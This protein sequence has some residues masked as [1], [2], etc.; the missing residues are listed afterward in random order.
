[1]SPRQASKLRAIHKPGIINKWVPRP[2]KLLNIVVAAPFVSAG[3]IIEVPLPKQVSHL[4]GDRQTV[5][6][7]HIEDGPGD[8][9]PGKER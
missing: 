6:H 7:V 2:L 5:F 1:M 4:A 9:S 3:R 8:V